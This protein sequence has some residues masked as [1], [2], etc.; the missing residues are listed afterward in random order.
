MQLFTFA[1]TVNDSRESLEDTV[2][3]ILEILYPFFARL[4]QEI[5]I[6]SG[7]QSF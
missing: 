7:A 6:G 4:K 1:K 3:E 2:A 5:Y